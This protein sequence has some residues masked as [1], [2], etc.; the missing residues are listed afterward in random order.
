MSE[1]STHTT[2]LP[3][4]RKL[5]KSVIDRIAAGEKEDLDIVCERFTTSKL[6]SYEDLSTIQTYGFRGEALASI[7]HVSHL[8]ITSK[9][10][11]SDCAFKQQL[12][13]MA[14]DLFYNL[15]F[16]KKALKN[17]TEEYNRV[18]EVVNKYS[19]HNSGIAFTCR[20]AGTT[21][22]DLSTPPNATT[23]DCIRLV[24]GTNVASSVESVEVNS[25]PLK[26]KCKCLVSNMNHE[27]R[28]TIFL[29]F[30]N[31]RL[32]DCPPLKRAVENLY[33]S[34][35]PKSSK[36]FAYID[37]QLDPRTVDVNVHPTKRE[38]Q[39]LNQDEIISEITEKIRGMLTKN[40]ETQTY[41]VQTL[42]TPITTRSVDSTLLDAMSPTTPTKNP[43]GEK[44]GVVNI[45][46]PS[47][48]SK[49]G[50][51]SALSTPKPTATPTRK[52]P[53]NKMVRTDSRSLSLESFA[54]TS[55]TSK[56]IP[57]AKMVSYSD[58]EDDEEIEL[59]LNLGSAP[60]ITRTRHKNSPSKHQTGDSGDIASPQGLTEMNTISIPSKR[61]HE[62][63]HPPATDTSQNIG[64]SAKVPSTDA[65][66]TKRLSNESDD[67]ST[68]S[69]SSQTV[70]NS[71]TNPLVNI[72]PRPKV[73]VRLTSILQLRQELKDRTNRDLTTILNNHNF[74]G[75][76]DGFRA[77]IQHQTKLYILDIQAISEELFYNITLQ[78]FHNFGHMVLDPP[79]SIYDMT[80][81]ALQVEESE[82]NLGE[83]FKPVKK[84]AKAITD[85][86]VSRKD[87][88][89]EYYCM[90]ISDDGQL[91]T[92]PL[93]LKEYHPNMT[94]L[95]L[96]LL[97]IGCEVDW[98]NE[99]EFFEGFSKE[100]AYFYSCEPPIAPEQDHE[101]AS[102]FERLKKEYDDEFSVYRHMV[103][104]GMFAALKTGFVASSALAESSN[105]IQIADLP[106][107][108]RIFERC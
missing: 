18:L 69:T 72:K 49:R 91:L 31:H 10:A 106:D 102:E 39:F 35:H 59:D 93:L 103:Q 41:R 50:T 98:S 5:D 13:Q 108:Y 61:R 60:V 8:T 101:D 83:E 52:L 34:I 64:N 20:K 89:D 96:F 48:L 56:P 74:V 54:F 71:K 86:V 90:K 51:S 55:P 53:V 88:L 77:L 19:I 87:M 75:F 4:I 66:A 42:L 47:S 104:H 73:N 15:T 24:Y 1:D 44:D 33:T 7:S 16:R 29:L 95:P 3:R 45:Q 12:M 99:R 94:K 100:L 80:L 36:P 43:N 22:V 2:N 81:L 105:I 21:A 32:V 78:D 107:L 14:E 97:R 27:N 67:S 40:N 17:I 84:V 25:T 79:V 92:L 23:L 26:F 62:D 58:S 6:R 82:A 30:I 65:S 11:E 85:L 57:R 46:I 9:T 68:P 37:I 38:V 63:I 70:V 76:V 28:K